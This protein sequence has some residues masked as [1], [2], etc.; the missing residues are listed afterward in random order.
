MQ[1]QE[2]KI[3]LSLEIHQA[4]RMSS[5]AADASILVYVRMLQQLSQTCSEVSD[6]KHTDR[7]NLG[8]DEW[9]SWEL[10]ALS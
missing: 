3:M 6:G 4:C 7:D 5:H 1:T 10:P 9:A 2:A 8:E